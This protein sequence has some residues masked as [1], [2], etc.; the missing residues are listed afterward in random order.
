MKLD[1][2][3]VSDIREMLTEGNGDI[4]VDIPVTDRESLAEKEGYEKR[5]NT[6]QTGIGLA[7][8]ILEV[9]ESDDAI[10]AA[11]AAKVG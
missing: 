9:V 10:L 7:D 8:K 2:E 3:T 6:L 4:Y 11:I 5:V 1:K